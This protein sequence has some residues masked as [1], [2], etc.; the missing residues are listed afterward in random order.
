MPIAATEIKFYRSTNDLGGLITGTEVVNALT[1]NLFDLVDGQG[2]LFGE[3]NYRCVYIKNTNA[4]LEFLNAALQLVNGTS[5]VTTDLEIGL[6]T[7][8]IGGI[9][10]TIA[11]EIEAPI[12]VIFSNVIGEAGALT[13]GTIPKGGH[14]AVWFKRVV[15]AN[16]AAYADDQV[17]VRITGESAS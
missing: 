9:E 5:S 13:I 16:T 17:T 1:H 14:K 10:Q 12:G 6:G 15:L 3:I 11:T 4:S 2:S 7:S 8:I